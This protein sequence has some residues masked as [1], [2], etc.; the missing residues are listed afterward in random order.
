MIRMLLI[1]HCCGTHSERRS[2]QE[3]SLN[4]AYRWFCCLDLTDPV[5]GHS[6]FSKNRQGRFRDCVLLRQLFEALPDRP[7][8]RRHHG[9]R[10]RPA[11]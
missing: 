1:G 5:L 4:L 7:Q 6:T 9:H 10:A 3:V 2:C 11:P 8:V